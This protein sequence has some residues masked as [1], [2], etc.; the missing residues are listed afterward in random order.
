MKKYLSIDALVTTRPQKKLVL[1]EEHDQVHC[2]QFNAHI[3]QKMMGIESVNYI[4]PS[5]HQELLSNAIDL[6]H[7][8]QDNSHLWSANTGARRI[9]FGRSIDRTLARR[10][11]INSMG[12]SNANRCVSLFKTLQFISRFDHS[13]G[14]HV[15]HTGEYAFSKEM[16]I[17]RGLAVQGDAVSTLYV[18][19]TSEPNIL[20]KSSNVIYDSK[21]SRG[22]W[23][24]ADEFKQYEEN[25]LANMTSVIADVLEEAGISL[26]QLDTVIPHNINRK[27]WNFLCDSIGISEQQFFGQNIKTEGHCFCNDFCINLSDSINNDRNIRFILSAAAGAG[28]MFGANVL[29]VISLDGFSN[30]RHFI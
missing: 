9:G 28:G 29:E 5:E 12:M 21:F 26:D 30:E 23:C 11:G 20:V 2:T 1:V 7:S 14:S 25:Y 4:E 13:F 8:Q 27:S 10:S 3:L 24:E 22:I 6:S 18:S 19:R 15:I 16:R 17:V